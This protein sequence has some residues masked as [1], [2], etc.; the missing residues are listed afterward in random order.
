VTRADSQILAIIYQLIRCCW[1]RRPRPSPGPR[2]ATNARG[3]RAP[4]I[5]TNPHTG[6]QPLGEP[7]LPTPV[8]GPKP[9][10]GRGGSDGSHESDNVTGVG[11]G[12]MAMN[13]MYPDPYNHSPTPYNQGHGQDYYNSGQADNFPQH[14]QQAHYGSP[15]RQGWVDERQ[16]NGPGYGR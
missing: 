11:A 1:V 9:T 14:H 2:A 15:P 3:G 12:G 6:Y 8:S 7:L 13:Q 5:V 4:P 10:H 16:Y